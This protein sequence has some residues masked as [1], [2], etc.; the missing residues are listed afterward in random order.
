VKNREDARGRQNLGESGAWDNPGHSGIGEKGG[1]P[2]EEKTRSSL[3]SR[4]QEKHKQIRLT[5]RISKRRET[6]E[7]MGRGQK[8]ELVANL[9]RC[10]IGHPVSLMCSKKKKNRFTY[11]SV[12]PARGPGQKE[13]RKDADSRQHSFLRG[14][15]LTRQGTLNRANK[16]ARFKSLT[17]KGNGPGPKSLDYSYR[18]E[19][20]G[21]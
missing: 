18:R 13:R 11:L 12:E 15:S 9:H 20:S 5:K 4:S 6:K 21:K 7:K 16:N 17:S 8:S 19:T 2:K 10:L 3:A 1:N 14:D